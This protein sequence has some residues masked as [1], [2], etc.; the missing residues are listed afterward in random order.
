MRYFRLGLLASSLMVAVSCAVNPEVGQKT[1]RK[2]LS[3]DALILDFSRG[4]AEL[5]GRTYVIE[6]C[7]NTRYQCAE[8]KGLLVISFPAQCTS[9]LEEM[10]WD[11]PIGHFGLFAPQAHVGAPYGAYLSDKYP[12]L[13]VINQ[14]GKGYV[15]AR[16]RE[17]GDGSHFEIVASDG[18]SIMACG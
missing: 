2:F 9:V 8:V 4:V 17:G 15:A 10:A 16:T 7:S 11:L 12:N 5:S 14:R 3:G 18:R 6:D 1:D 13:L